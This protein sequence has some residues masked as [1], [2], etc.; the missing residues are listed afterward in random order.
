MMNFCL[1]AT[2]TAKNAIAL[3]ELTQQLQDQHYILA[4]YAEYW[5]MLLSLN[6]ADN[7]TIVDF[8]N[9]YSDYPFSAKLRAEY[10]K[11]LGREQDWSSFASEYA[12][13]KQEDAAVACY[14][15]E[16]TG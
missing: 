9:A 10:L 16:A 13:Y 3:S 15:A 12:R 7:K 11:K 14:A 8:I 5:L 1:R 6:D 2:H 4:P